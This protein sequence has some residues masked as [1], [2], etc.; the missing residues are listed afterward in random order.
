[1]ELK[2]QKLWSIKDGY[3]DGFSRQNLQTNEE[4]VLTRLE[5]GNEN[6]NLFLLRRCPIGTGEEK[7]RPIVKEIHDRLDSGLGRIK[8]FCKDI[9]YFL[10]FKKYFCLIKKVFYLTKF[11]DILTRH[12]WK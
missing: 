10:I 8:V 1:M 12:Y 5:E 3:W 11:L 6:Y 7:W 2:I 4:L 9:G